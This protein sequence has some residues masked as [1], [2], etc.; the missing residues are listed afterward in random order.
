MFL[1]SANLLVRRK[2][3]GI[4]LRQRP[5]EGDVAKGLAVAA[6]VG[7]TR[8][9]AGAAPTAEAYSSVRQVGTNGRSRGQARGRAAGGVSSTQSSTGGTWPA[10]DQFVEH[11]GVVHEGP[12]A[13]CPPDIE[14]ARDTECSLHLRGKNFVNMFDNR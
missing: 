10:V 13:H 5:G 12:V 11:A 2:S 14:P 7:D 6:R 8:S 3:V 9:T 1:A 4:G